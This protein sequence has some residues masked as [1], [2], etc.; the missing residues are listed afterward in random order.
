ARAGNASG[1][2]AD[3]EGRGG[4]TGTRGREPPRSTR[5]SRGV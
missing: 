4:K 5:G 3:G 2:A 1:R